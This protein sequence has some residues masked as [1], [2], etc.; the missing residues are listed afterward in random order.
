MSDAETTSAA[1]ADSGPDLNA[2]ADRLFGNSSVPSTAADTSTSAPAARPVDAAQTPAEAKPATETP[3]TPGE[4][5]DAIRELRDA[6]LRRLYTAEKTYSGIPL[7]SAMESSTA[8]PEVKAMVARE[9][10]EWLADFGAS[11]DDAQQIIDAASRFSAEP[12]TPERDAANT[13]DAI[14]ALNREFGTDATSALKAAQQMVLRD[15]RLARALD[16][17]RLGNCPALVVKLAY[18]ARSAKMRG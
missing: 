2:I 15:P 7:E 17:S 18:L 13:N 3:T 16:E 14:G 12:M 11:T 8:A 1:P 4:L 5:P 10:R 9:T 6:P